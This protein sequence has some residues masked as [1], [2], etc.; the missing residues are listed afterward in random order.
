[1]VLQ[2]EIYCAMHPF[3]ALHITSYEILFNRLIQEQLETDLPT[4]IL[5]FICYSLFTYLL[6]KQGSQCGTSNPRTV[7]PKLTFNLLPISCFSY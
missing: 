5:I 1:M 4:F 2:P 6:L 7:E 3:L